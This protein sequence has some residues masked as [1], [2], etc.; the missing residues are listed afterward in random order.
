[1][2]SETCKRYRKFKKF[3]LQLNFF[4]QFYPKQWRGREVGRRQ[5]GGQWRE[6]IL[7]CDQ[8]LAVLKE[9]R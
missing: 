5:E 2:M 1:M 7:Q 4:R 8:V 9:E 3:Q 6:V